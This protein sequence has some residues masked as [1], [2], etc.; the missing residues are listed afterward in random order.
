MGVIA[1]AGGVGGAKLAAG[2]HDLLGDKLTVVVNTGDDFE[3]WGLSISPDLDT[4]MY[5]LAG[6][7]NAQT[8]WGLAGETWRVFEAMRRLDQPDWFRLGDVDLATHLT[9]TAALRAGEPLSAVTARLAAAL[10]V[11]ATI[12]PM[13]DD[14]VRTIVNTVEHGALGFQHYFVRLKTAP[15]VTG[16]TFEGAAQASVPA[17]LAAAFANDPEALLIGPSNPFVS[18]DPIR[19][20]PGIARLLAANRA[21]VV[22]V[23]PIVGGRALKGPAAKMMHELD[24][25]VSALGLAR[26]YHDFIDALV[27]DR[28]DADLAPAIEAMGMHVLVTD[29]V[30]DTPAKRT[31]VAEIMLAFARRLGESR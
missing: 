26:Y 24:M 21:P 12:V 4:V 15:A 29:T 17:G 13:S 16:F 6:L 18:I 20:V 30:M 22:A 25:P 1:L 11:R 5:T 3:H 27:I 10:G 8:G 2:L 9:R 7:N 14:P 31:A 23:S 28:Q 19:A